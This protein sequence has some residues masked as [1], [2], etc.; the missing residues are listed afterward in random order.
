MG[1]KRFRV[2]GIGKKVWEIKNE[3]KGEAICGKNFE[4]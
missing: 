2:E 3:N 4:I 1:I